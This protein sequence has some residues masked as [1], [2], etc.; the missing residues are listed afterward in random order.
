MEEFINLHHF[1]SAI[2]YSFL[3]IIILAVSFYILEKKTPQNLWIELIENKN[4][5]LA[6]IL[7]SFVLAIAIIIS[8]AIR[9]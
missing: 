7:S 2:I 6:I 4:V 8:A 3:G 5:A 9:G 1:I